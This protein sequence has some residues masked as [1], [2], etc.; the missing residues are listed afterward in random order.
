MP[1]YKKSKIYKLSSNRTDK[2]YIGATT[3]HLYVRKGQHK[4]N[5]KSWKGGKNHYYTSYE[6]VKY[7]DC[8]II[9][10]EEFPCDSK[11]QLSARERYWIEKLKCVNKY[12][13]TRTY[14]EWTEDN[15]EQIVFQRKEYYKKNKN[16][17]TA[18]R[19]KWRK[20]KIECCCG[21]VVCKGDIG[22]HLKTKNHLDLTLLNI[23]DIF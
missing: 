16:E 15:K 22:G 18:Y 9:L 12:I 14:K 19:K 11:N 21:V 2:I 6:I 20:Q 17:I 5:Y 3:N 10:V 8:K 7:D 13:P 23:G 4:R 1:D